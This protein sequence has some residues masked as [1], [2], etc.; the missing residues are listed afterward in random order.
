[1]KKMLLLFII[2]IILVSCGNRTKNNTI[3]ETSFQVSEEIT[4]EANTNNG[5]EPVQ[6]NNTIEEAITAIETVSE[7]IET[8]AETI[9]SST[10]SSEWDEL[11]DDYEEY[12]DDYISCV[13]KANNGDL[14]AMSDM[15]DL[16][17]DTQ[18][19]QEDISEISDDLTTAQQ[20]R[21]LKLTQKLAN[22][23]SNI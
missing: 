11:L 13:K 9:D 3:T 20:S 2:S 5:I 21:Y 6:E 15:V 7:T 17:E 1:M 22:S 23:L 18:E 8:S 19:L 12:I 16:L 14:S 10:K 4:N